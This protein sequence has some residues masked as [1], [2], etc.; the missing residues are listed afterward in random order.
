M[1]NKL[2]SFALAMLVIAIP[3]SAFAT[4]ATG[5]TLEGLVTQVGEGYF[6]MEDIAQGAVRVNLDD[7][8]T[9]YEGV[10]TRDTLAVGQYVYVQ[11]NGIMT[12]SLP[13]QVTA[14]KVS[15][16]AITGSV[17]QIL[18]KSYVVEGDAVFGKVLV[19]MGEQSPSVYLGVPVTIYYSGIM[20]LS[21]PPQI[22]AVYVVVPMLEGTVTNLKD[23]GF[24]LTDA[25]GVAH[26]IT[27]NADTHT[28]VLLSDGA[29]VR[30]YYNG[31]LSNGTDAQ[32]L[33]VAAQVAVEPAAE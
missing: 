25:D 23:T 2:L 1:K 3:I 26:Q 12:R 19:H 11:Y 28:Q 10:V 22:S 9:V 27:L 13:P 32:A 33:E 29:Q 5:A 14:V 8:L 15:C 31:T 18:E 17:T 16:F 21:M 30:V 4:Q 24:T 7:T 20:A 6:V